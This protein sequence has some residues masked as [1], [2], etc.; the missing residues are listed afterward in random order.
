MR[1]LKGLQ[2]SQF[3]ITDSKELIV[4]GFSSRDEVEAGREI[5]EE[6][7]VSSAIGGL[8]ARMPDRMRDADSKGVAVTGLSSRDGIE[9]RLYSRYT[10]KGST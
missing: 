7:F 10:G 4:T 1:I 9:S 3:S 5:G 2:A 8:R 6:P